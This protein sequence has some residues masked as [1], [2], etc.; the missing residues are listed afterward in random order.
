M[1]TLMGIG[2]RLK[3]VFEDVAFGM[4]EMCLCVAFFDKS[5]FIF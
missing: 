2:G 3:H 5:V 1:A 4:I